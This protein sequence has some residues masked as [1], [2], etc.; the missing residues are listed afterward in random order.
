VDPRLL[1]RLK[2][3][4]FYP[5]PCGDV[6]PVQTLTA[7]LLF[8]GEFVYKIKKPVYFSFIDARTPAKRF[9][10]CHDEV[11]RNRRLSPDVYLGVAGLAAQSE[12]YTLVPN[13]SLREPRVCEFAIVMH[14]LP[15]DRMLSQMVA[16]GSIDLAEIQ[17]LAR[18]LAA[19]HSNCSITNARAWGSAAALAQ[20]LA[21]TVT[22][23]ERLV[24]DT[25]MR[26]KLVAADKFLRGY[27]TDHR[28]LLDAR[29][30][31][32]RV[33]DGH[34]D[35]RSDCV[36][37]MPQNPTIIGRVEYREGLRY[38]DVA[39]ELASVVLDLE[40]AGRNDLAE[41]LVRSYIAATGD[42]ELGGLMS[43]YKCYRALR[44]GQL[45]LLMSV[46]TEIPRDRRMLAR[47]YASQWFQVAEYTAAAAF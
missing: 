16:T 47:N 1:K 44:R 15:R 22:E 3:P 43:F 10:L 18:K 21:T 11:L 46:Q 35:L 39:S 4:G 2:E 9:R 25:I 40:L 29:A 7:W 45:Q 12:S 8:A 36:C 32:G 27:V 31:D 37:L 33:R 28:R 30:R 23:A 13:A 6:E 26:D 24:A 34:G 38:C 14:R 17:Q 5:H 41:S 42:A 20:L 19:F